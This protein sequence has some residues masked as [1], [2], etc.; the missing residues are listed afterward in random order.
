MPREAA[1]ESYLGS[2]EF[3]A[4]QAFVGELREQSGGGPGVEPETAAMFQALLA[5]GEDE[6]GE[7]PID[8]LLTEAAWH[9][10][11]RGVKPGAAISGL[12]TALIEYFSGRWAAEG[13]EFSDADRIR[14]DDWRVPIAYLQRDLSKDAGPAAGNG[15]MSIVKNDSI[16]RRHMAVEFISGSFF[17]NAVTPVESR[18]YNDELLAQLLLERFPDGVRALDIGCSLMIGSLMLMHKAELPPLHYGSV[19]YRPPGSRRIINLTE[20]A[21]EIV[22]RPPAYREIVAVD[23]IA[24]FEERDEPYKAVKER[25][26]RN[27]PG[28]PVRIRPQYDERFVSYSLN[29]LRPS[30]RNDAAYMSDLRRLLALKENAWKEGRNSGVTFEQVNLV[31]PIEVE[32]FRTKYPEPFDVIFMNYVTQELRPDDQ[33][34]LHKHAFSLLSDNG[35]IVYQHQA[36]ISG[37]VPKPAP[38]EAVQPYTRYASQ[39]WKS[40]MHVVDRLHPVKPDGVQKMMNAYDNRWHDIRVATGK[41]VVNGSL[42]PIA[43]LIRHG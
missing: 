31:H 17:Y 19:T 22:N 26:A 28:V 32:G 37:H 39:P 29:G 27:N 15:K 5:Y 2:V 25:L 9:M 16:D 18:Y 7:N 13:R 23:P 11:R 20:K 40:Q 41:L 12:R 10:K 6:L 4:K 42:E 21:D 24:V 1:V 34:R 33:V 8:T 14:P 35:I 38:I 36:Y 43:D 3:Q 30:E